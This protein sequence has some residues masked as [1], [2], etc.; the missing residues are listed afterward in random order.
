MGF[1]L[2]LPAIPEA[3][4]LARIAVDGLCARAGIAAEL[5]E[6]IRLAVSEACTNCVRHA[7]SDHAETSTFA[8]AACVGDEKLLVVVSDSGLGIV[9][10][11]PGGLGLGLGLI[12]QLTERTDVLSSPG[13][14]T[15]VV[16]R[17]ATR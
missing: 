10:G 15:R 14:G 17:F 13:H 6:Q 16:M 4:P 12:R 3:V 11:R 9:P 7:Y 2:R 5:V 1:R 8:L